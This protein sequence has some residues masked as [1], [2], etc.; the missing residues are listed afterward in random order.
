MWAV[1]RNSHLDNGAT[2]EVE[3]DILAPILPS[4]D[5]TM[6]LHPMWRCVRTGYDDAGRD[7][8]N[9]VRFEGDERR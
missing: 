8:L 1:D 9:N 5:K 7:T 6:G 2:R 4:V 3:L